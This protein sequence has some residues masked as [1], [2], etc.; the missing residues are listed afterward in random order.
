[1]HLVHVHKLMIL[2][3]IIFC[4][5]FGLRELGVADGSVGRAIFYMAAAVGLSVYLAWFQAKG[6]VPASPEE[7]TTDDESDQEE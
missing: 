1:M 5:G 3:G 2:A 4:A 7:A 6:I